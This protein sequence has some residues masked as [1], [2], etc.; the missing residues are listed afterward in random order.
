MQ[1][2]LQ[3]TYL[4]DKQVKR[5]ITNKIFTVGNVFTFIRL[6]LLPILLYSLVVS[7]KWGKLLPI[8]IGA[9]MALTDILDGYY[10]RKLGQISYVG[11]MMDP[12]IDKLIVISVAVTL[13]ILGKIH[14]P[15][16]WLM[17]IVGIRYIIMGIVTMRIFLRHGIVPRSDLLGRLTPT[18]WAVS[19]LTALLGLSIIQAIFFSFALAF[20][21]LNTYTYVAKNKNLLTGD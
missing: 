13:I 12:I 5:K 15:W 18:V 3:K 6:I 9:I 2:N 11:K 20:T 21:A 8:G 10:A 19:F 7:D 16:S 17:I 14:S 4:P 1:K